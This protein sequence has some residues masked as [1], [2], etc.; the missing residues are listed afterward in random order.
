MDSVERIRI[1]EI[2]QVV[3]RL[4]QRDLFATVHPDLFGEAN[5][6][7]LLGAAIPDIEDEGRGETGRASER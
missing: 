6:N 1:Q 5:L 3:S 7:E 4:N 2:E